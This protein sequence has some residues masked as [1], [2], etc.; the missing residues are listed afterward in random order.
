MVVS[1]VANEGAGVRFSQSAPS[2]SSSAVER[3]PEEQRVGCSIHP[4]GTSFGVI[5]QFGRATGLHPVDGGSS[6]PDS[7]I[8][9]NR[10]RWVGLT[11]NQVAAGSNPATGATPLSSNGRT[12]PSQGGNTGS[13]PVSGAKFALARVAD[14]GYEPMNRKWS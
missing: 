14:V 10:P 11:V 3:L 4:L 5:A 2:P 6:P 13:V 12:P 1:F 8:P 7:T 9:V